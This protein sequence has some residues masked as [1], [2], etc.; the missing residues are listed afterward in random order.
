M[1]V[2]VNR[3]IGERVLYQFPYRISVK[4]AC[5]RAVGSVYSGSMN[6]SSRECY[7][8]NENSNAANF[9]C[10]FLHSHLYEVVM[11]QVDMEEDVIG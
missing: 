9:Y 1:F 7:R 8:N 3:C 4:A 10:V 11:K 2:R 5:S 6:I